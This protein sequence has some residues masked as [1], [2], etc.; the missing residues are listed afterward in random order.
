MSIPVISASAAAEKWARRSQ[1]ATVDYT[2]GV[3]NPS[4]DWATATKA[5]EDNYKTSVIAAANAG[6]FGKGVSA[7]GSEKQ[8]KNAVEKGGARWAP[9]I[10]ASQDAFG[11]GIG[12]VLSTVSALTL[13]PRGVKGDPRN[14]Q[15]VTIVANA[16]HQMKVK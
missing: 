12:R 16:L 9:G 4:V 8:K 14:L 15:R 11:S 5:S 13:P 3:A 6:R 7:A 2:T 1:G 10:A